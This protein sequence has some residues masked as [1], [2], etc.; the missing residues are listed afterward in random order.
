M[1]PKINIV[2]I[3]EAC[4]VLSLQQHA[5][6]SGYGPRIQTLALELFHNQ[7]CLFWFR[8]TSSPTLKS[9]VSVKQNIFDGCGESLYSGT[10]T[11]PTSCGLLQLVFWF[12][13]CW[14]LSC[15]WCCKQLPRSEC[16]FVHGKAISMFG[17]CMKATNG[18]KPTKLFKI[19]VLTQSLSF[20]LF[21]WSLFQIRYALQ[22]HRLE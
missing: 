10:A 7:K 16:C 1:I 19:S 4:I 3:W 9:F 17:L 14:C 20:V 22:Q 18:G 2:L 11:K 21:D 12:H 5:S 13:W 15:C 6:S 8:Q